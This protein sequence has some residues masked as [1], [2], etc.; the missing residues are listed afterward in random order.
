MRLALRPA[1][2]NHFVGCECKPALSRG[3]QERSL[4]RCRN[5]PPVLPFA[6]GAGIA[7]NDPGNG[8]H[9]TKHFKHQGNGVDVLMENWHGGDITGR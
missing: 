4:A 7:I 3:I 8:A 5:A 9:A 2:T 1:T 6:H